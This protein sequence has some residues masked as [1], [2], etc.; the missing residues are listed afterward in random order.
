LPEALVTGANGFV[1][2][3]ICEALIAA[4]FSVRALV[5]KTSNLTNLTGV[6][7]SLAYGDI[8]DPAS[9]PAAMHG[10]DAII[11]N[12][13]IIKA[14]HPEDFHA[15]NAVGTENVL[16]AAAEHAPGIRRLVHISSTAACGPAPSQIPVDEDS[17]PAPLTAYGRSKLEAERLVQSYGGLLPTVIL[18]P[19]AVYGPRDKEMLR[20]FRSVKMGV[21]LAF[22]CSQNHINFTY[23]KDLAAA[24]VKAVEH[25]VPSGAIFFVAEKRSYAYNEA[26][27]II[28]RHLGRRAFDLY[29]PE[30]IL[31]LAGS[32]SEG[33]ARIRHKPSIFTREKAREIK[34]RY[35]LFDTSKAERELGFTASTDFDRGAAETIRWYKEKGWL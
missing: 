8:S 30:P 11:N 24:V 5:R 26:G 3:H 28:A 33:L 21:K 1:G 25:D 29:V 7:V 18:R 13:A 17:T 15:V 22:G 23:V 2:S 9:L 34:A 10:V 31:T 19:C 12:A 4:G 35:W 6:P 32:L 16:K 14:N 20:F 27:D